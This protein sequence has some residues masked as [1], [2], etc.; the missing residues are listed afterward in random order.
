MVQDTSYSQEIYVGMTKSHDVLPLYFQ[1]MKKW[2]FH[3]YGQSVV[4]DVDIHSPDTVLDERNGVYLTS[5]PGCAR[6][7]DS[8]ESLESLSLDDSPLRGDRDRV[9]SHG[10][11]EIGA[12]V[13]CYSGLENSMRVCDLVEVVGILEMPDEHPHEDDEDTREVIIHAVTIQK[14][15][16]NEIVTAKYGRLSSGTSSMQTNPDNIKKA[17]TLFIQHVSGLFQGDTLAAKSVLLN[18]T[19]TVTHRSPVP[20]GSLPMNIYST[21]AAIS[22]KITTLFRSILPALAAESISLKSLNTERV[23]PQSDGEKLSAG[24]GQLVSR[25]AMVIEDNMQEGKLLDTGIP[26]LSVLT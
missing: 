16:L 3:R 12:V 10:Q 21:P 15:Q 9:V 6:W 24:R 23:Y 7:L 19:S 2:T 13:K 22:A 18:M 8:S 1:L 26:Y 17:Q 5:I 14:R 11:K 20:L 4:V 25:T